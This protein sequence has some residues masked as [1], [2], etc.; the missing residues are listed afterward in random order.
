MK[1]NL[2]IVPTLNMTRE[3][4]LAYRMTGIGASETACLF[5]LDE[6][7]S[8]IQLFFEK[9]GDISRIDTENIY[10]FMGREQEDLIARLWSYWS[11][12][13]ET[14]IANFR[15]DTIQRRCQRV[16][17]FVRNP[18]WEWI[19]VSL[20][21]K[22]NRHG[23][24]NTEGALE[25]KNVSGYELD[26]WEGRISP[27]MVIQLQTQL[28]VCEF[29]YG[30]LAIL[31]DGRRMH[32]LPFDASAT[33]QDAIRE[34]T[35]AFWDN[36]LKARKF[37]NEKYLPENMYNVKRQQELEAEIFQLAPPPDGTMAYAEYLADKF[38]KGDRGMRKGTP[39]ELQVAEELLNLTTTLKTITETK[40]EKENI[41]K[42]AMGDLQ[43]LEFGPAGKVYWT[44]QT[45]GKRIFRNKII[46]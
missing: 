43:V 46:V 14:M 29:E 1:S 39:Q 7:T 28:L 10:Q 37:V 22:I 8:S 25:L 23:I 6:F 27:K 42:H 40:R 26:K 34:R 5:G 20:D 2:I 30:E 17:A 15:A 41:L 19:F 38:N 18:Q 36:V 45:D 24:R 3:E 31:E 11:G 16:N 35:K 33:I 44:K 12:T 32:V 21:R 4:W 9:I 13:E